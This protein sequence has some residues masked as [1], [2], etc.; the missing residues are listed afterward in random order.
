MIQHMIMADF[1]T[2]TGWVNNAYIFN[3]YNEN[4]KDDTIV[5]AI[6]FSVKC[7]K[8]IEAKCVFFVELYGDMLSLDQL[9]EMQD[10]GLRE[11]WN[12]RVSRLVIADNE[13]YAEWLK[14]DG[15]VQ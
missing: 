5:E 9:R 4:L 3:D 7:E 1:K 11:N 13:L 10:G 8:K 2:P 15:V 12:N 6:E 14:P